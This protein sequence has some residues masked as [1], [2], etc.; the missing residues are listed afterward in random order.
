MLKFLGAPFCKKS[1]LFGQ[2]QTLP[3]FSRLS[4]D[5]CNLTSHKILLELPQKIFTF[6]ARYKI[7]NFLRVTIQWTF[8]RNPLQLRNK[9]I[10]QILHENY[11][12]DDHKGKDDWH[13][14]IIDHCITNTELGER[15]VYCQNHLQTFFP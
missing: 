9:E 10:L 11:I 14:T 15:Q 6:F 8:K 7:Q 1:A 5:F 13:F 3:W 4:P 12:Q 2:Y